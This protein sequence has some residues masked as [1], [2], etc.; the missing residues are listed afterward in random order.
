MSIRS[1]SDQVSEAAGLVRLL[2]ADNVEASREQI[3]NQLDALARQLR[4]PRGEYI[5]YFHTQQPNERGG[6]VFVSERITIDEIPVRGVQEISW[7]KGLRGRAMV[8]IKAYA[9]VVI[10]DTQRNGVVR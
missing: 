7:T 10:Q 9:S 1:V 4:S 3:A 6:G 8:T 5:T 2:D